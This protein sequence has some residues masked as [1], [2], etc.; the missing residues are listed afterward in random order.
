MDVRHRR[1]AARVVDARQ[2]SPASRGGRERCEG[3]VAPHA[4]EFERRPFTSILA[5]LFSNLRELRKVCV[6]SVISGMSYRWKRGVSGEIKAGGRDIDIVTF[7]RN[8]LGFSPDAV[9][10]EILLASQGSGIVNCSRQWGKSTVGAAMLLHE[11]WTKPGSLC[12]VASV[13]EKQSSELVRKVETFAARMGLRLKGDG[14]HEH[15]LA[16]PNGSR[17]VALPGT[18]GSTRGY[19]V[20]LLLVDE[21]SRVPD[22]VYFALRPTVAMGGG[23]D[24]EG[25]GIPG[26]IWLLSTPFGKQGFF[27]REWD[28]GGEGWARFTVKGENCPRFGKEF[29]EAERRSMGDEIFAQEYCCHFSDRTGSIFDR[30]LMDDAMVGDALPWSA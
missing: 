18:E 7:V 16:L 4:L 20:S 19:S 13:A 24:A 14:T 28:K 6:V 25:V 12:M 17:I 1:E 2:E 9:Q 15:S 26:R 11:A 27:W 5:R 30:E 8:R 23:F 29:L 10:E 21:A 3:H 22:D